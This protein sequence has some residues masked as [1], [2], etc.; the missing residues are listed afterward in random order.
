[1]VDKPRGPSSHDVVGRVRRLFGT[2]E[3]GHAGTLDP[4]ATGVLVVAVGEATKLAAYLTSEDKAYEATV[5]L[6]VGT[7]TLDAEGRE[8]SRVEVPS[9][10]LAE[11]ANLAAE[12]PRLD[13]ALSAER[14]RAEQIPPVFSAIKQAGERAYA[15]ARRGETP[16]LEARPVSV[17][18]L[19][20]VAKTVDP[21]TLT[22]RLA[23]TKGYYVRALA[24][25][26]AASLGSVGHLTALRRVRSGS[27][28]VAEAIP[29]DPSPEGL[30]AR[31]I[32]LAEAALRALP[33]VR[34]TEDATT[35]ARHGREIP[36]PYVTPEDGAPHAWLDAAGRLVA[37]GQTAPDGR[38]KVLR[39][40]RPPPASP[41]SDDPSV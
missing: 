1:V 32:P 36:L 34:L 10:V 40:F 16:A 33:A 37:I 38:A 14:G 23:V 21:P 22:V 35:D 4:M 6:G 11:L 8:T 7:A 31:L 24:R 25:D 26:L 19:E 41:A 29:L 12:T 20:L 3:V 5:L 13:A 28:D 27:F 9:E 15:K 2:R 39:G 17:R 18:Q 30:E